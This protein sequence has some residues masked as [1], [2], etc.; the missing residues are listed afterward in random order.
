MDQNNEGNQ[1][2]FTDTWDRWVK[3]LYENEVEVYTDGSVRYFNSVITRVLTPPKPLRQPVHAQGGILIH[4]GQHS[5]LQ[6]ETHN[7]TITLEQGLGVEILSRPPW[8]CTQF[9]LLCDF[10]IDPSSLG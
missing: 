10:C 4:F 3:E 9:F 6:D 1:R 7:I 8:N 5:E 2:E